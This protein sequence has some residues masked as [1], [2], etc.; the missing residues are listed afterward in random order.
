M[1]N[2]MS[3]QVHA[4]RYSEEIRKARELG[5]DAFQAWFNISQNTTEALIRGYWDFSCH[6]LTNVVCSHIEDPEHKV[7]LEIG[8]GGGRILNAACSFFK[9]AIGIDIHD[10][11]RICRKV[12]RG[13]GKT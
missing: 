12:F 4:N 8:Y 13:A 11:K 9:T 1:E 10:E 2:P 5:E 3:D 7:C 6:I